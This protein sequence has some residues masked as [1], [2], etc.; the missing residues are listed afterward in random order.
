M[1]FDGSSTV[2]EVNAELCR[3]MGTR[4]FDHSGFAIHSDDPLEKDLCHALNMDDKVHTIIESSQVFTGGHTTILSLRYATSYLVGR[5]PYE[6]RV[7][8]SLKTRRWSASST[9]TGSTGR[10]MSWERRRRKDS[11]SATKSVNPSVEASSLSTG[12]SAWSWR[13]SCH[14]YAY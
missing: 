13:H 12:N 4:S 8:A 9:L 2:A 14:K 6:K 11:S 5:P 3:L 1:G 10:R 7:L